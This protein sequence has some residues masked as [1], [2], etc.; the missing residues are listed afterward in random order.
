MH[1]FKTEKIAKER[2]CNLFIYVHFELICGNHFCSYSIIFTG[3][4]SFGQ[5]NVFTGVCHS[6]NGGGGYLTRHPSRTRQVHPPGTRQVHPPRDQ[7]GT[8]PGTR[9]VH[10]LRTRQIHPTGPGRYTPPG[11]G[12]YPLGPGRYTPLGPGRYPPDQA[13]TPPRTR[14]VHPPGPGRYTPPQTRQVPPR[15]RYTPQ[16]QQTPEYGQ[17]SAGTHPTG[18]HSCCCYATVF[19]DSPDSFKSKWRYLIMALFLF[20][21]CFHNFSWFW[22]L[23]RLRMSVGFI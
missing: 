17:R 8:P 23:R 12:R 1:S 6:V 15:T 21:G 7:A 22:I 20:V 14:Q 3:Q 13:G 19:V 11:P 10:P 2:I 4:K 18:M 9:Q 16:K 5:G